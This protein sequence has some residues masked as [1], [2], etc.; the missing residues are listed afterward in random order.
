MASQQKPQNKQPVVQQPAPQQQNYNPRQYPAS[1]PY[2]QQQ[3]QYP[4]HQP[5]RGYQGGPP[6]P[7]PPQQYGYG[8]QQ[9][10]QPQHQPQAYQQQHYGQ[11]Q[12]PQQG[13]QQY[14]QPQQGYQ[15]PQAYPQSSHHQQPAPQPAPQQYRQQYAPVQPVQAVQPVQPLPVQPVQPVQSVQQVQ[16]MPV[17]STHT[18]QKSVDQSRSRKPSTA[19]S[20]I[21]RND[22]SA[23]QDRINQLEDKVQRLERALQMQELKDHNSSTGSVDSK[24]SGTQTR[25]NITKLNVGS[26]NSLIP[27][28][29]RADEEFD[30]NP[31]SSNSSTEVDAPYLSEELESPGTLTY[32][33]SIY[34]TGFEKVGI[35]LNHVKG[36]IH[37]KRYGENDNNLRSNVV[38][39]P[40]EINDKPTEPLRIITERTEPVEPIQVAEPREKYERH[41]RKKSPTKTSTAST[42]QS[43]STV[44]SSYTKTTPVKQASTPSPPTSPIDASS[45]ANVIRYSKPTSY[46]RL[47]N[48]V[49]EPVLPSLSS[50]PLESVVAHFRN[51]RER[52][53]GDYKLF[54]PRIQFEWAITL[55]E[56]MARPD[57]LSKMAIDGK[58]RRRPIPV[59]SLKPQR[60]QFLGT[61]VKVLEKLVQVSPAETRARLYLADILSGGIHPG[62]IDKDEHE[63]FRLFY[64]AATRQKDPVACYRIACCLE[65]GVG[66]HK[67][68]ARSSEFFKRGAHLGDPSA[69]CQLGMMYFAGVN[70]FPLDIDKSLRWHALAAEQLRNFDVMGSDSLISARSFSD[71]RG[72]LYTLGKLAQTDLSILCLDKDTQKTQYS[73]EQLE[74]L[75]VFR[76]KS[77]ALHNY[78]DAAKIGHAESQASLGFYYS[79]GFFPTSNF[80][81]D[82]KSFNGVADRIDPK[83]SI[84]WFSKAAQNGH[85]YAALGLARW[86]GSGAPDGTLQ[87]DEQQAFLWG[88]KAADEGQ[89]PEAEYMIGLCFEQGFGTEKNP[90][91]ARNYYKRSASKGYK[92]AGAKLK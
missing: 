81:P 58:L 24:K 85:V 65:A 59:R 9:P 39:P 52:A 70:G 61:A 23:E 33:K 21:S 41:A 88:R 72:A 20:T 34:R 44:Q 69:M 13:Y 8:Y 26:S 1:R 64:D 3:P 38:A 42:L 84:Y 80:R 28:E 46:K 31:Q 32:S 4:Q 36:S 16:Q 48:S 14:Q 18:R 55:L 66:C 63:G 49:I 37:R 91:M 53:L 67:D 35:E 15:Q 57:V 82:K 92:K 54:T 51:T 22:S 19:E 25:S 89:L 74:R 76:N 11:Y 5:N 17:Q 87:R 60:R 45:M 62:V 50:E 12:Q 7:P 78:L 2:P 29:E 86:Y 27:T 77:K 79:K 6:L 73:I 71:A 10:Q 43:S 47:A 75:N 68:V 56:T 83:R 30:I 90:Q 40:P